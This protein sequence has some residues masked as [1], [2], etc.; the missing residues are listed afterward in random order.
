MRERAASRARRQAR[1]SRADAGVVHAPGGPVASRISRDPREARVLRGRP[2]AGALRRG[3]APARATPRRRRGGD[4][5]RH[6]DPGPRNGHRRAPRR[7]RRS[8]DR[9]AHPHACRCRAAARP[10]PGGGVRAGPRG[11]AP[12]AGGASSRPGRRRLLRWAVHRR[13]VPRRGEAEPRV[14]ADEEHDARS[15]PRSGTR[16]SRSFQ[17][18][19]PPTSPRRPAR[20]QT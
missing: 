18:R 7:G 19:S 13:R 8:R 3:D 12:R 15:S 10:G 5:R 6:H 1:G 11:R 4:V 17:R 9:R 2:H 20:A 16:S 14:R